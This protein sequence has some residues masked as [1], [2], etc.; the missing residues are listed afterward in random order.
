MPSQHAVC[1]ARSDAQVLYPVF[2]SHQ[3]LSFASL[4]TQTDHERAGHS[5]DRGDQAG[6]AS[7]N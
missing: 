3:C 7:R 1:H 4:H 6:F 2:P 5:P